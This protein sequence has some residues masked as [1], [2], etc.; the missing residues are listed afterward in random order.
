LKKQ[1]FVSHS[2]FQ[3]TIASPQSS[4]KNT[5]WQ[6]D[7][8]THFLIEDHFI[9]SVSFSLFC[10]FTAKYSL[11]RKCALF[12]QKRKHFE[13]KHHTLW[14]LKFHYNHWLKH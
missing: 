4:I 3:E 6:K 11:S 7:R 14:Y 10:S 1:F 12:T 9:S 13:I 5:N 2:C 8:N